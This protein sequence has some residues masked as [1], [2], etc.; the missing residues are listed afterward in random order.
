MMAAEDPSGRDDRTVVFPGLGTLRSD[1]VVAPPGGQPARP[2]PPP[3]AKEETPGTEGASAVRPGS[4]MAPLPQSLFAPAAEAGE[5]AP[6]RGERSLRQDLPLAQRSRGAGPRGPAPGAVPMVPAAATLLLLLG[7]LRAG[8]SRAS[9][10]QLA[11]QAGS[12]IEQFVAELHRSDSSEDRIA[13]G[14]YALCCT[15][16]D[17]IRSLPGEDRDSWA[18]HSMLTR[19]F[20]E[21]MRA[22]QL[23]T[24]IDRSVQDPVPDI[25]LLELLHACVSLGYEGVYRGS[26]GGGA[27]LSAKRRNLYEAIARARPGAG[28]ALSP[29]WRGL[30]VPLKTS[31]SGVPAWPVAALAGV[32]LLG[33]YLLLRNGLSDGSEAVAATLALA[34]PEGDIS[35]RRTRPAVAPAALVV[36]NETSGPTQLQRIKEALAPD[37][38]T[39]SLKVDQ[40]PTAITI[41]ISNLALFRSGRADLVASFAPIAARI[42]KA[43]DGEPG[44]IQVDGYSDNIPIRTV[45]FAS[46]FALSE[47]RAGA[48][49]ALLRKDISKP[50][51][52]TIKGNGEDNPIGD[53]RT[54]AGREL[55]RRV[56][57]SIPRQD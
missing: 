25:G 14:K 30:T 6:N 13:A 22:G 49:A 4:A 35:I 8:L 33:V 7:R 26:D 10:A 40:T 52:L 53:N 54:E 20:G 34:S 32:V 55:N 18:R 9:H 39:K 42:A 23:L 43:L 50:D 19:F 16:D 2:A 21:P 45:A 5:G 17:V 46:N 3:M 1:T 44:P 27:N 48:V 36:P 29:H 31:Q 51:R 15:A 47:A 56:E 24:Q 41:R 57:L 38:M 37:I 12:A 28:A 11:D